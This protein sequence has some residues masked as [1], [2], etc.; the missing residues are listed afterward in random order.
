MTN[1]QYYYSLPNIAIAILAKLKGIPWKL[2][3]KFK[4]ELIVGIG[5]FRNSEVDIQYIG[6]AFSFANNGKFNQS[7]ASRKT[8]QRN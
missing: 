2:D 1:E 7:N 3:T 6:S 4:N 8:Q 5:A